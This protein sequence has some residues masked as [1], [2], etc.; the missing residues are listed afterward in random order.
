[1]KTV[2]VEEA[3]LNAWIQDA[4]QERVLITRQGKPV[5]LIIGVEGLDEEQLELGSS[6]TFWTLIAERRGQKTINRA[7]LEQRI[8]APER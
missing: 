5:A 1:M 6:N 7:E 2:G 4:Q 8:A 3:D